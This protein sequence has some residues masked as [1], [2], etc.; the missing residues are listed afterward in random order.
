M[1]RDVIS[2]NYKQIAGQVLLSFCG[3]PLLIFAGT[4][5]LP[6]AVAA[7]LI[8]FTFAMNGLMGTNVVGDN[9]VMMNLLP[10]SAKLNVSAKVFVSG[11][12]VGVI[13]SVPV[14][15]MMKNG[16]FYIDEWLHN[17]ESY[18]LERGATIFYR[19]LPSYDY[20]VK[21]N[22][23]AMDVAVGDLMDSGAGVVQIGVMTTLIPLILFL[24]GCYF[25]VAVLISQL[26]LHP[27]LKRYPT[28]VVSVLAMMIFGGLVL[29]V[30]ML[31]KGS[32]EQGFLS[33]FAGELVTFTFFGGM[34]WFLGRAAAKRLEKGYDV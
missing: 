1:I 16:G 33:L 13:C 2:M 20:A 18:N 23:S 10:V 21:A 31:I 32:M 8:L 6:A 27:L 14:F 34:T 28:M 26:Y 4:K 5:G 30:L 12:W 17:V 3:L 9:G 15:L 29:G 24:I 7:G 25:G 11:S 19:D 22:P